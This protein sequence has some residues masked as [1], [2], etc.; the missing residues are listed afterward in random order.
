MENSYKVGDRENAEPEEL[1]QTAEEE[2]NNPIWR[3][4]RTNLKKQLGE[5]AFNSWFVNVEFENILDDTAH[6]TA[7]TKFIKGW[8]MDNYIDD[9]KQNFNVSG[10]NINE[11]YIQVA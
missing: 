5:G 1:S 2:I 4:T 8:I 11:I 3:Q 9:I 7:P 6:L 10:A